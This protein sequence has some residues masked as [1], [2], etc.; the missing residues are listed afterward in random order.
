MNPIN[1][2]KILFVAGFGPITRSDAESQA[3]YVDQFGL[4][5]KALPNNENYLSTEND[6]LAGVKHFALWP[7]SQAAQAC[8][9]TS[10]WPTDMAIPQSWLEFEV[11]D[12]ALASAQLLDQ[13][14]QLLVNNRMEPWGQTVTRL[15]SPEGILLGLT[16]TP[17]L[18]SA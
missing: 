12:I 15:L 9:G 8:F 17:W 18:R 10:Q 4:P 6:A 16:V 1:H 13:S 14:Y 7:L 5:L 3:L 11:D 2:I